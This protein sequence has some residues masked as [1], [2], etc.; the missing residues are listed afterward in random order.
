MLLVFALTVSLNG[1]VDAKATSY[2]RSLTRCNYFAR[3]LMYQSP[4]TYRSRTP[5]TAYCVPIYKNPKKA[6]IHD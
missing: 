4:N 3:H 5:V 1:T 2:W 6:V